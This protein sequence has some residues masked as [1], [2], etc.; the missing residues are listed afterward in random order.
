MR[1]IDELRPLT[2]GQ[3]LCIRREVCADTQD[4]LERGA[5]CN[6][7]VL[8]ACCFCGG[9]NVF[10]DAEKV[11]GELTFREMEELLRRWKN[12]ER[13]SLAA[14]NPHFDEARF[15]CLQER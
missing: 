4:E 7:R 6:A 13:V 1:V 5:L 2:A 14:V 3:L 11:L 10:S 12:G 15:A 8:A 9:E